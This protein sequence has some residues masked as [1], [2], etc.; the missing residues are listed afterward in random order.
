[1]QQSIRF[2]VFF[3]YIEPAFMMKETGAGVRVVEAV[4]GGSDEI[5][6]IVGMTQYFCEGLYRVIWV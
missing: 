1:M 2:Q 4:V 5:L 3:N 6:R